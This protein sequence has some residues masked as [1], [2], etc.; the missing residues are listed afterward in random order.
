M[1]QH[2][3]VIIYKVVSMEQPILFM[4]HISYVIT[5]QQKNTITALLSKMGYA[6]AFNVLLFFN[7][8]DI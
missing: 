6:V 1:F 8:L 7:H 5:F 4:N 3:K 2:L